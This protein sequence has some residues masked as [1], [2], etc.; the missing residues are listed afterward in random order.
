MKA[1]LYDAGEVV[2]EEERIYRE[3]SGDKLPLWYK[4]VPETQAER[5]LL[6]YAV[7]G[8]LGGNMGVDLRHD[9]HK[10]CC[11]NLTLGD[12]DDEGILSSVVIVTHSLSS[13]EKQ[14]VSEQLQR[15]QQ[16]NKVSTGNEPSLVIGSYPIKL[17]PDTDSPFFDDYYELSI[18]RFEENFPVEFSLLFPSEEGKV[19]GWFRVLLRFPS[20][21]HVG[22][23]VK[24]DEV[25]DHVKSLSLPPNHFHYYNP[26]SSR[27]ADSSILDKDVSNHHDDTHKDWISNLSWEERNN[28][29]MND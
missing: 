25:E 21:S 9:K 28:M 17:T 11:A 5:E 10:Q 29:D 7:A 19:T 16:G 18:G 13:E 14:S 6:T 26:F 27:D 22:F 2:S 24:V 1:I 3:R 12:W 4:Q 20:T 15:H 23:V 8:L